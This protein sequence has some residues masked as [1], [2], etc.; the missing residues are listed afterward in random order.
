[1]TRRLRSDRRGRRFAGLWIGLTLLLAAV[2]WLL[3]RSPKSGAEAAAAPARESEVAPEV[4]LAG[5]ESLVDEGAAAP[6][7]EG[8]ARRDKLTADRAGADATVGIREGIAVDRRHGQPVP[9][10]RFSIVGYAPDEDLPTVWEVESDVRGEFWIDPPLIEL[11]SLQGEREARL[12]ERW[13]ELPPVEEHGQPWRIEFRVASTLRLELGG[14]ADLGHEDLQVMLLEGTELLVTTSLQQDEWGLWA[15]PDQE[16]RF[17][18]VEGR[19]AVADREGY[20]FGSEPY[21]L[22][23]PSPAKPLRINLEE[24]GAVVV[25]LEY[26]RT[27]SADESEWWPQRGVTV[28]PAGPPDLNSAW[29]LR[30]REMRW[31][32]PASYRVRALTS[33]HVPFERQVEVFAGAITEVQAFVELMPSED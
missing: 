13:P 5:L 17:R 14:A 6:R 31:L 30:A 19:V 28:L 4:E 29:S 24:T 33:S 16:L 23:G 18:E 3:T 9:H 11:L 25:D 8:E 27:G 12:A 20:R 26:E 7:G 2:V 15:R 21:Q 22:G 10:L 1:M 32:A